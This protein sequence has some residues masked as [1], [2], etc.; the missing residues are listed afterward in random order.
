MVWGELPIYGTGS[1]DKGPGV[2]VTLQVASHTSALQPFQKGFCTA[3]SADRSAQDTQLLR[4]VLGFTSRC[5]SACAPF[6]I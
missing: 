2:L 1:T 5:L 3:V 4:E 6:T